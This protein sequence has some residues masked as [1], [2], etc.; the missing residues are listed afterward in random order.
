[1]QTSHYYNRPGFGKE[2]LR[3]KD[4]GG[5]TLPASEVGRFIQ[6]DVLSKQKPAKI[7]P[8][9]YRSLSKQHMVGWTMKENQFRSKTGLIYSY[10]NRI[11]DD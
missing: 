3:N 9:E 1:M 7:Q 11:S 6:H 5:S 4:E 2:S 10:F 8:N